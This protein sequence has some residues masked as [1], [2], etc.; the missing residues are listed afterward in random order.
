MDAFDDVATLSPTSDDGVEVPANPQPPLNRPAASAV[1]AIGG[2]LPG[3][4]P[5]D[6]YTQRGDGADDGP[7][8][9]ANP[10]QTRANAD[11]PER[12]NRATGRVLT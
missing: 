2:K 11:R 8:L 1:S 4:E 12:H 10:H 6:A 9:S 3:A 7:T 5:Q